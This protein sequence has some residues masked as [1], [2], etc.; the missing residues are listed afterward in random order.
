M[1]GIFRYYDIKILIKIIRASGA[2]G[3]PPIFPDP[4][5]DSHF[6]F[7]KSGAL[8]QWST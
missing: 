4:Q 7:L 5:Q 6:Y 3:L 8:H 1:L 2:A